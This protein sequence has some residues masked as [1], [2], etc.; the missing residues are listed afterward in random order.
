V[1]GFIVDDEDEA[2]AAIRRLA[3]LDRRVVRARFEERFSAKRMAQDYLRNY[4]ALA[5]PP[6]LHESSTSTV[7]EREVSEPAPSRA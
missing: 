4:E 2:V 3:E 7:P 5:T 1:T 6:V